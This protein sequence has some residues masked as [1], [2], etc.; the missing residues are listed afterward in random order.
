MYTTKVGVGTLS[1]NSALYLDS[2]YATYPFLLKEYHP[3]FVIHLGLGFRVLFF[4][5]LHP[6]IV[7]SATL[8]V[9]YLK[10]S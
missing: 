5:I 6:S 8:Y 1:G 10:N 4:L 9:H 3:R 2:N 7:I